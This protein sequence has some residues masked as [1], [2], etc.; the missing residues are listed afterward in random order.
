[1]PRAGRPDNKNLQISPIYLVQMEIVPCDDLIRQLQ[2]QVD[3]GLK[4]RRE[5]R[6]KA[7]F[8]TYCDVGREAISLPNLGDALAKLNVQ[9][10]SHKWLAQVF[11]EM[12][13]DRNKTL[14]FSEFRR[15][16]DKKSDIQEWAST[17][18]LDLIFADAIPDGESS[19]LRT[20][21]ANSLS[22]KVVKRISVLSKEEIDAICLVVSNG[23]RVL[24]S[25]KVTDLQACFRDEEMS[26]QDS[27]D[28]N[29]GKYQTVMNCGSID[30]FHQGLEDRVGEHSFSLN[31]L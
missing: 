15:L 22:H 28:S 27:C 19:G 13:T 26:P 5:Q 11:D 6:I 14:D 24:L 4:C 16:L 21:P 9:I 20:I 7:V 1:M 17:L 29:S 25:D 12:D 18:Q 8:E 10:E 2:E 30:N 31:S 3:N 23:L